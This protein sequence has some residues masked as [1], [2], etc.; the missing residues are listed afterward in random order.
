MKMITLLAFNSNGEQICSITY[1]SKSKKGIQQAIKFRLSCKM[2]KLH[3][4]NQSALLRNVG[5]II[6]IK[7]GV[8]N[9]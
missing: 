3:I 5:E 6:Q 9:D 2:A 8:F 7:K 4:I 1:N